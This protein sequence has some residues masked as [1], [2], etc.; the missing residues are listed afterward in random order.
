MGA[1]VSRVRLVGVAFLAVL[2]GLFA[3]A[4]ALYGQVFRTTVPVRLE[5][6]RIGLVMAPGNDVKLRG[7]EVGRVSS[8]EHTAGGAVLTLGL[9][10]AAI[11]RI[12]ANVLA[13]IVPT[14]AFG[15]KYVSLS[16]PAEPS[17]AR[18]VAGAALR[19]SAVTVE[20]NDVFDNLAT[21]LGS[22]D[23]AKV[24]ATLGELAQALDGRG[25]AI[26]GLA[27]NADRYLARL[28]EKLP[29]LQRDLVA[30][31]AVSQLYA[32]VSPDVLRILDNT[33]VTGATIVDQ[34]GQ[35]DAFL[36]SVTALART[37]D[38]VLQEN[39]VPLVTALD[40]LRPTTDLLHE[41]DPMLTCFVT[42]L[43][44]TRTKLEPALG[45]AS[46]EVRLNTTISIG[47]PAYERPRNLPKIGADNPPSCFGLPVV[48][49]D[50]RPTP[51]VETDTGLDPPTGRVRA[52]DLPV[53]ELLFGP[54]QPAGPTGG[55]R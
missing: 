6:D 44:R 28:N 25:D 50:E 36:L 8:V 17:P 29:V 3:L 41:Y 13:E 4:G 54:L 22:V 11:G 30:L 31:G 48:E 47:Q 33:T 35:L 32:D 34:A 7:V 14:T 20:V 39:R 21:L 16:E 43:D 26:A 51:R 45:G 18:I 49:P 52:G 38:A 42:G 40:V 53:A 12:P 27:A 37:G 46:P 19:N 2:V 5:A 55:D 24:N 15:T 23:P 10:P 9:D 1:S